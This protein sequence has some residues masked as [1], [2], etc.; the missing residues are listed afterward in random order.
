MI[1]DLIS[2]IIVGSDFVGSGRLTD[3]RAAAGKL[4]GFLFF[5]N[6]PK[7]IAEE[8]K[9]NFAVLLLVAFGAD[10]KSKSGRLVD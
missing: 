5:F 1:F 7:F 2:G 9:G 10:V 6:L 4:R 3:T 8:V